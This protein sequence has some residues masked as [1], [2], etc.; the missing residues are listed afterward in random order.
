MESSLSPFSPLVVLITRYSVE[1][2]CGVPYVISLT[3]TAI[4]GI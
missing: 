4:R 1:S 3:N 2:I